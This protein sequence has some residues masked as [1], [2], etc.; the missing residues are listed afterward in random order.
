MKIKTFF[1]VKYYFLF[2][3]K[4][5]KNKAAYYAERLKKSMDGAG[6]DDRTLIR[7][8]VGRSE[9]DLGDIKETYERIYEKSLVDSIAVST[10]QFIINIL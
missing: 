9:I 8:V 2:P 5:A 7:I 6:T 1:N 10:L 3:V 4:S